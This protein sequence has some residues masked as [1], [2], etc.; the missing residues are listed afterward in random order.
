MNISFY[1]NMLYNIIYTN[2]IRIEVIFITLNHSSLATQEDINLLSKS[3]C[4]K[5]Y[6]LLLYTLLAHQLK[7]RP[8]YLDDIRHL[9]EIDFETYNIF[10]FGIKTLV[11]EAAQEWFFLDSPDDAGKLC[12]LCGNNRLEYTF[13][14]INEKNKNKMIVG[15][16]CIDKFS[17]I[18]IPKK[19]RIE[20]TNNH[21]RLKRINSI[22]SKYEEYIFQN[23]CKDV[24]ELLKTWKSFHANF[25]IILPKSI[26]D[27]M[28]TLLK[29]SESFY[30]SFIYN[31]KSNNNVDKFSNYIDTFEKLKKESNNFYNKYKDN[32]YTCSST[33]MKWLNVK[34]RNSIK[35]KQRI[36]NNNGIIDIQ[37][38]KELFCIDF[39]SRF[40]EQIEHYFKLN[41]F[42]ID[43][44][45]EDGIFIS[46][47]TPENISVKLHSTLKNFTYNFTNIFF[48]NIE[49]GKDNYIISKFNLLW[50]EYNLEEYFYL[51]N[52]FRLNKTPYYI[53]IAVRNGRLIH[54][55]RVEKQRNKFVEIDD[56]NFIDLI[57]SYINKEK[58]LTRKNLLHY[59]DEIKKWK[60]IKDDD[61]KIFEKSMKS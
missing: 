50:D 23:N 28:V 47:K 57:K 51:L 21:K 58:K 9:K 24:N 44:L 16:S 54:S 52:K 5:R 40:S 12:Q 49:S 2:L 60:N 37:V 42:I 8:I 1:L 48:L 25:P 10:L 30:N 4:T 15:S 3:E 36:I 20:V 33:L 19:K 17:D 32:P 35:L 18:R 34:S 38:A 46:Y 11:K 13:R 53:K 26:N 31:L 45:S 7:K 14:I 22:N 27:K 56:R 43:K 6:N 59:F 41:G 61:Y 55:I 29:D 39:I